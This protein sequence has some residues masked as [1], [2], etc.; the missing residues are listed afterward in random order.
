VHYHIQGS[1]SYLHTRILER[2][3]LL[4]KEFSDTVHPE[5]ES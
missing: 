3:N 1:K 5:S 2:I 4:K